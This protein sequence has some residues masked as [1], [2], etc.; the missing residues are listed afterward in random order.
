MMKEMGRTRRAGWKETG[1]PRVLFRDWI[2]RSP[3]GT[4][5]D[6]WRPAS[7]RASAAGKRRPVFVSFLLLLPVRRLWQTISPAVSVRFLF[8][9]HPPA[10]FVSFRFVLFSVPVYSY[11][12]CIHVSRLFVSAHTGSSVA[13]VPAHLAATSAPRPP[14]ATPGS[15]QPHEL[16]RAVRRRSTRASDEAGIL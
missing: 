3:A 7:S 15:T 16:V 11:M 10:R 14:R 8:C 1:R 2:A 13:K 4:A 6:W 9:P 5:R 12:Y